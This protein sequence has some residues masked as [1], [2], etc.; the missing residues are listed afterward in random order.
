MIGFL[1]NQARDYYAITL[2]IVETQL[3]QTMKQLIHLSYH[4]VRIAEWNTRYIR[5]KL[6][7]SKE[8]LPKI[9]EDG[10]NNFGYTWM[11]KRKRKH[12]PTLLSQKFEPL[13][14]KFEDYCTPK[15]KVTYERDLFDTRNQGPTESIDAYV[16]ALKT[17]A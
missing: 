6:C 12:N 7:P 17:P 16:T 14:K 8:V 10:Y 1:I 11:P 5:P 15:R 3:Q 9:G 13:V 4:G 2:W